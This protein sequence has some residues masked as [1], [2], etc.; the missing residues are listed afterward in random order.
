[1]VLDVVTDADCDNLCVLLD[2]CEALEYLD[3]TEKADEHS[4]DDFVLRSATFGGQRRC[5]VNSD[6]V[7]G[8]QQF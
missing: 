3:E 7:E 8:F 1:M 6:S 2:K 5:V 4:L